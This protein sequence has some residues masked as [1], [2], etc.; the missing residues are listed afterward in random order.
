MRVWCR[1]RLLYV[2]VSYEIG[3]LRVQEVGVKSGVRLQRPVCASS[4]S[5]VIFR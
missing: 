1:V 5:L 2:L 4:S 3:M